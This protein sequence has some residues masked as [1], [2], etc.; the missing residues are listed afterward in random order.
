MF[1]HPLAFGYY[2]APSFVGG[3]SAAPTFG[4]GTHLAPSF[5]A[6]FS[7][8]FG[9]AEPQILLVLLAIQ[10]FASP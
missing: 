2:G 9:D 4:S 6:P 7:S 5:G 10:V 3:S 1:H 8:S